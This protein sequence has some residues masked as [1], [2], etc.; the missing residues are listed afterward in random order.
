MKYLRNSFDYEVEFDDLEE[1]K[2]YYTPEIELLEDEYLGNEPF[3]DYV[4]DFNAYYDEI[5]NAESLEELAEILTNNSDR[6]DNGSIFYV[7]EI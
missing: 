1:A 4:A 5:R 2:K 7:K 3:E 6:F